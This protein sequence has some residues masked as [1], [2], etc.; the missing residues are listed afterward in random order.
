MSVGTWLRRFIGL[1]GKSASVDTIIGDMA[2]EEKGITV[3]IRSKKK[4]VSL[5]GLIAAVSEL[6]WM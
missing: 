1:M 6:F 4:S 3:Y 5:C 2:P